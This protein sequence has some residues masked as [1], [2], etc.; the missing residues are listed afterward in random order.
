MKAEKTRLTAKI[1]PLSRRIIRLQ[2][3][4]FTLDFQ[5]AGKCLICIQTAA[6]LD[7]SSIRILSLDCFIPSDEEK[8]YLYALEA[9]GGCR[10]LLLTDCKCLDPNQQQQFAT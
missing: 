6:E 2:E 8:K 10:G 5:Y 4:G 7:I 1:A 9:E 3:E